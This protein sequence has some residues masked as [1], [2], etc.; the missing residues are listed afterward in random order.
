MDTS[1]HTAAGHAASAGSSGRPEA[2]ILE[3]AIDR[4]LDGSA[5]CYHMLVLVGVAGSGKSR[6]LDRIAE[7]VGRCQRTLKMLRLDAAAIR[8]DLVL[9]DG[10][11]LDQVDRRWASADL[12]LLDGIDRAESAATSR[13]S[14]PKAKNHA[15]SPTGPGP[16]PFLLDRVINAGTRLIVTLNS[17]PD[18][19]PGISEA[20]RSRLR[21]GLIV[22]LRPPIDST[23]AVPDTETPVTIRRIISVTAKHFQLQPAD[24]TGPSRSRSIA[25]ARAA[26][27][28]LARCLSGKSLVAIGRAFGGRDHTT[29][30][31]GIRATEQRVS[32]TPAWFA[33][34]K[35]LRSRCRRA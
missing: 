8:A 19:N 29:V 16:L 23:R 31:H 27:M 21:G 34:I 32:E 26:A 28:Y 15:R 5:E 33:E 14:R 6:C 20:T 1:R 18:G 13:S 17:G 22:P 10:D 2:G 24:L 4:L 35:T 30:M 9:A 7:S 3:H 12:L 11:R 25:Q